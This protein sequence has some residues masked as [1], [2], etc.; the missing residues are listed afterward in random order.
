MSWQVIIEGEVQKATYDNEADAS[1]AAANA[2]GSDWAKKIE[3]RDSDA[4]KE[5]TP[6]AQTA[7]TSPTI[8]S[9]VSSIVTGVTPA[10]SK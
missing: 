2:R 3:V 6:S 4:P 7:P 8:V 9:P 10:R 5:P 1:Q